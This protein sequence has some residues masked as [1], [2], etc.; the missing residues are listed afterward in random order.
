MF[1]ILYY[2]PWGR[3]G[4]TP[5]PDKGDMPQPD[6]SQ[7]RGESLRHLL[8]FPHIKTESRRK[9]VAIQ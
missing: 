4:D 3:C 1:V 7:V 6:R 9:E 2:V 8:I 5:T